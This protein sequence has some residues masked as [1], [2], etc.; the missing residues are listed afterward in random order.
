MAV[1]SFFLGYW[2][3]TSSRTSRSSIVGTKHG[4]VS[5]VTHSATSL[6]KMHTTAQ[7]ENHCTTVARD[8][9][10]REISIARQKRNVM[11]AHR[12]R[13]V[14][15]VRIG[16][17]LFIGRSQRDRQCVRSPE[18]QPTSSP[19]ERATRSKLCSLN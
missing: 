2:R 1:E 6:K 10:A 17:C 4:D 12:K 3:V 5:R 16:G 8:V 9:A 15:E 11:G 7:K 13:F 18:R 14:R 19:S